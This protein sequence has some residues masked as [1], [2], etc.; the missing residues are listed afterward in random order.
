MPIGG[1]FCKLFSLLVKMNTKVLLSWQFLEPVRHIYSCTK[2]LRYQRISRSRKSK[3]K[4]YSG[5]QWQ[6][7]KR[8]S[9]D[10]QSIIQKTNDQATRTLLITGD[11]LWCSRKESSSCSTCGTRPVTFVTNPI[12]HSEWGKD[13]IVIT[14]N[15][16]YPWSFG[17]QILRSA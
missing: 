17:T 1:Y 4:Q 10:L 7:D 8:T 5:Q 2:S 13:W 6:K 3:D 16:A 11:E 14:K 9:N 15:G 12:I